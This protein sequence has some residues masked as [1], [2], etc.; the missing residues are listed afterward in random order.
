MHDFQ[1]EISVIHM[2]WKVRKFGQEKLFT[3]TSCHVL[4][5]FLLLENDWYAVSVA[6]HDKVKCSD[7]RFQSH[8]FLCDIGSLLPQQLGGLLLYCRSCLIFVSAVHRRFPAANKLFLIY[9]LSQ[10]VDVVPHLP[11]RHFYVLALTLL[12]IGLFYHLHLE[13]FTHTH[14]HSDY[15]QGHISINNS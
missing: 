4:S 9:L 12:M 13:M 14:T 15:N 1:R 6:S 5:R 2:S 10:D 7:D 3:S 8:V 11:W